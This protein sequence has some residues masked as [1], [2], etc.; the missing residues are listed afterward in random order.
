MNWKSLQLQDDCSESVTEQC[1][2]LQCDEQEGGDVLNFLCA[3][4]LQTV[5]PV[6]ESLTESM[7]V[8]IKYASL[9]KD[10]LLRSGTT[11]PPTQSR[12][13]QLHAAFTCL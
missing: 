13:S 6:D 1:L 5:L 4:V 11:T 9:C 10:T 3:C 8:R 2:W 7:A 12:V